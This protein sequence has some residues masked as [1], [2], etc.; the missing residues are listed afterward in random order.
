MLGGHL[1]DR[2]PE[3]VVEPIRVLQGEAGH[4]V[5]HLGDRDNGRVLVVSTGCGE[6]GRRSAGGVSERPDADSGTT[7][8][9][10]Q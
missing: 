5:V 7:A 3:R 10:S 4:P 6:C 2:W 1:Q 8:A 9:L